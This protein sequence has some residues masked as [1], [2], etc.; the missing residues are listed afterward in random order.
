MRKIIEDDELWFMDAPT[1]WLLDT[2]IGQFINTIELHDDWDDYE[3]SDFALNHLKG[4][5]QQF[6]KWF[7][8]DKMEWMVLRE[9]LYQQFKSKLN[10]WE[11]VELR[12][13]LIQ[14]DLFVIAMVNNF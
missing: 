9:K 10:I 8:K 7:L 4:P 5:A 12:K 6:A 3:K 1:K 11:K 13:N 2:T 14:L